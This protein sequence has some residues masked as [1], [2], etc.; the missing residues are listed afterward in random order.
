MPDVHEHAPHRAPPGNLACVRARLLQP[1]P[2]PPQVANTCLS[3]LFSPLVGDLSD[4]HGRKPFIIAGLA[5]SV[6]P[7]GVVLAH[8]THGLSLLW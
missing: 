2:T 8:L 1:A 7:V 4:A 3:F 5:L 6:L